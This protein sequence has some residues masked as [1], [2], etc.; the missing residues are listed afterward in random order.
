MK[1]YYKIN[2]INMKKT[3]KK[4]NSNKGLVKYYE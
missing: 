4:L 1:N 3:S 2:I